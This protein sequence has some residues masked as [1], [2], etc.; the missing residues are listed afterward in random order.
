[1]KWLKFLLKHFAQS[2]G[3]WPGIPCHSLPELQEVDL[4]HC[5]ER[6]WGALGLW[7]GLCVALIVIGL[8]LLFAWQ[9]KVR[10]LTRRAPPG[11]SAL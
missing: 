6:G 7:V 9:R 3:L 11:T 4:S 1:M 8:V 2:A 10:A 5:F